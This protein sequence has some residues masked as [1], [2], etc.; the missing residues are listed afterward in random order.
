MHIT[1]PFRKSAPPLFLKGLGL[2]TRS[3]CFLFA[4]MFILPATLALGQRSMKV[5]WNPNPET[6]IAGYMVHLGTQ[7]GISTKIIDVGNVSGHVFTGLV[8]ATTYFCAVQAY[9]RGGVTSQL[10]EEISFTTNPPGPEITVKDSAEAGLADG[11]GIVLFDP[12]SLEESGTEKT[13]TLTNRGTVDLTDLVIT[14]DGPNAGD[15]SVSTFSV[16]TLEPDASTT[17]TIGYQPSAAGTRNASVHIASNDVDEASFDISFAGTAGTA[18][19]LFNNWVGGAGLSGSAAAANAIPFHDGVPN[20]LKFAF[21]LNANG[22]DVRQLARGVGIAGLPTCTLEAS[23]G[24][25]LFKVEFLQRKSSGLTY[26]PKISSDLTGFRPM[27]GTTTKTRINDEWERVVMQMPCDPA[28]TPKLFGMVEVTLPEAVAVAEIAVRNSAGSDVTDGVAVVSFGTLAIGSSE[29]TKTFMMTNEGTADLTGL[30]ISIDG[31]NTAGLGVSALAADTLEPGASTAF[32]VTFNPN[33][34]EGIRNATLHV[35][36]N[37]AD[38]AP[39]DITLKASAWTAATL[40]DK[41][42]AAGGLSG[43]AAAANAIPFHDGVPNL[44]KF[45]FN[46]NANG[47]DMRQLVKGVGIAGLPSCTLDASGAQKVFKIEFIQRKS[48]G[49]IYTPKF[50]TDLATFEP[51]SGITTKTHINDEWERVVMQ[52]SCDP[53]TTPKLFGMVEVTLP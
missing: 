7:S 47:S 21:N 51:M 13:F 20:L 30:A 45:A 42:A 22:A 8:P 29:S 43:S 28:I 11:I 15:F 25:K 14:I 9:N 36:S 31:L 50:S 44:L 18:Y 10:S 6:D 27:T 4:L 26:T 32:T 46:L 49:L 17:F 12:V 2:S 24:Q 19:G 40:F 37:D 35:T 48:S 41:W 34:A 53:E 1:S 33:D 38:E 39:F 3:R 16:S 5:V 23:G 52:M